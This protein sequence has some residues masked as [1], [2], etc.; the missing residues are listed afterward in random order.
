V[1]IGLPQG[2]LKVIDKVEQALGFDGAVWFITNVEFREFHGSGEHSASKVRL[3]EYF[4]KGVVDLDND[5][6]VV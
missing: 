5:V 1:S 6:V 2:V 3:L 4:L